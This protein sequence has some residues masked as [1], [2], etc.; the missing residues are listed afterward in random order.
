MYFNLN[1][2]GIVVS[3]ISVI[4]LMNGIQFL[5]AISVARIGPVT[6]MLPL[7]KM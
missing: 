2:K 4:H 7:T 6:V 5:N 1:R 3:S